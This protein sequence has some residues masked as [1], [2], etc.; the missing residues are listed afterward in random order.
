M[1][2]GKIKYKLEI[3]DHHIQAL[4]EQLTMFV[5]RYL[6]YT[7]GINIG[8]VIKLDLKQEYLE[9]VLVDDE[10]KQFKLNYNTCLTLLRKE[11][12]S[13]SKKFL[14]I[15][16]YKSM[17]Q[18]K[19]T[20]TE[21]L[22]TIAWRNVEEKFPVIN[23]FKPQILSYL[24]DFFMDYFFQNNTPN[25]ILCVENIPEKYKKTEETS[26]IQKG[27][28]NEKDLPEKNT[29]IEE[30]T[31]IEE[32]KKLEET[33][34]GKEIEKESSQNKKSL[35]LELEIVSDESDSKVE[36]D[37]ESVEDEEKEASTEEEKV[38][39][40]HLIETSPEEVFTQVVKTK[41][42]NE[43][44][45]RKRSY[46]K[47]NITDY[48]TSNP[49]KAEKEKEKE[50]DSFPIKKRKQSKDKKSKPL[51]KKE[52]ILKN[53]ILKITDL[54]ENNKQYNFFSRNFTSKESAF[55]KDLLLGDKYKFKDLKDI[56]DFA[57]IQRIP[58]SFQSDLLLITDE[59]FDYIKM[60]DITMT[61]TLSLLRIEGINFKSAINIL[62][63][64]NLD[65]QVIA[66][67]IKDCPETDIKEVS[68]MD[69]VENPLNFIICLPLKTRNRKGREQCYKNIV[70]QKA[71]LLDLSDIGIFGFQPKPLDCDGNIKTDATNFLLK[72]IL[73]TMRKQFANKGMCLSIP[74]FNIDRNESVFN[75]SSYVISKDLQE[76][77][78]LGLK[79]SF[80][81]IGLK[82]FKN[83]SKRNLETFFKKV[84]FCMNYD[85][86]CYSKFENRF[87]L[88]NSITNRDDQKFKELKKEG[89]KYE[90]F[91]IFFNECRK[92]LKKHKF[93]S[94]E[95]PSKYQN[96]D[97]RTYLSTFLS[98]DI[99]IKPADK[100]GCIVI[101]NKDDYLLMCKDLLKDSKQYCLLGDCQDFT[102]HNVEFYYKIL[103][104]YKNTISSVEHQ[105]LFSYLKSF[106]DVGRYKLFYALPKIH[107]DKK[108]WLVESKVPVGRPVISCIKSETYALSKFVQKKLEPLNRLHDSF[109]GNSQDLINILETTTLPDEF[110]FVTLDIKN[111]YTN[112][113][114]FTG[115]KAVKY[116]EE[117]YPDP[118]RPDKFINSFLKFSL[119]RN[120]FLFDKQAYLQK[121]GCAMGQSYAPIYANLY[122]AYLEE[123]VIDNFTV[124]PFIYKRYLD[125]IFIIWTESLSDLNIFIEKLNSTNRN[126]KFKATVSDQQ[127][128]F[129]D[130]TLFKG[131]R[132]HISNKLD[133]VTYFKSCDTFKLLNTSSHHPKHIFKGILKSQFLRFFRNSSSSFL[134]RT[135]I[136]IVRKSLNKQGY[137]DKFIKGIAKKIFNQNIKK[138]N[139]LTSLLDIPNSVLQQFNLAYFP[140]LLNNQPFLKVYQKY[141]FRKS[142]INFES[143]NIIICIFQCLVCKKCM[144]G[145]LSDPFFEILDFVLTKD[146]LNIENHLLAE[147]LVAHDH[148]F[149]DMTKLTL[150]PFQEYKIKS[151]LSL[152]KYI[153]QLNLKNFFFP[154]YGLAKYTIDPPFSK[155]PLVLPF[156]K[157][158]K[159]V[160]ENLKNE[161]EKLKE[162]EIKLKNFDIMTTNSV[163]FPLKK[164]I[165]NVDH[166]FFQ[167]N[168]P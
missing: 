46:E 148:I 120:H 156:K 99:V 140:N 24:K 54:I 23:I 25:L 26:V 27:N 59:T 66:I 132:F 9:K 42:M 51:N 61:N 137:K 48:L 152:L 71:S 111:M 36:D 78:S 68:I 121:L 155:I 112:L 52:I 139:N 19:E 122:M 154:P 50:E 149:Q 117:K 21:G 97:F 47:K 79:F 165:V 8:R 136:D 150:F 104:Q 89:K 13:C 118:N 109:I 142:H 45:K 101:M 76:F 18:L 105:S 75:L 12:Q 168:Y 67:Y 94:K 31:T 7:H 115:L 131:S 102:K 34:V 123:T 43:T 161:F 53:E 88:K 134:Y 166:D 92:I 30:K 32:N 69:F 74:L 35:E 57:L 151:Y 158:L 77:L 39:D 157:K 127:I 44:I 55:K 64:W 98:S 85:F 129:L 95:I 87:F 138:R 49:D 162:K 5:E 70:N 108:D 163:H 124:K 81:E 37:K 125:D 145:Y 6:D 20:T 14:E 40:E 16:N 80:D 17:K 10:I 4:E 146:L 82:S 128:S 60:K 164:N 159:F 38:K 65:Y 11:L 93:T 29:K 160:N 63:T 167:K 96:L 15:N 106:Y 84:I 143:G 83:Q 62:K 28:D 147:N 141:F 135:T 107:K 144:F 86:N 58:Y 72:K 153:H 22:F 133:Y 116:F 1:N 113:D 2:P 100:G 130:L 90:N 114:T 110:F 119:N 56:Q 126:L 41:D 3:P 103:N 33:T 73:V 91:N